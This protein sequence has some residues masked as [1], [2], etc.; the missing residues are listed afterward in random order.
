MNEL[1]K[2]KSIQSYI[3][4]IYTTPEFKA[5]LKKKIK[6]YQDEFIHDLLYGRPL[7]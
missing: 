6:E 3:D 2:K 1:E 7:H 4:Y 5:A